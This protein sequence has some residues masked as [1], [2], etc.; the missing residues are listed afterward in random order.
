MVNGDNQCNL[1]L[2]VSSAACFERTAESTSESDDSS[3]GKNEPINM[4]ISIIPY[5]IPLIAQQQ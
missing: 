4:K 3:K 2:G 5:L 1:N